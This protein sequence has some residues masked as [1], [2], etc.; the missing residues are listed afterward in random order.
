MA[1]SNGKNGEGSWEVPTNP[2]DFDDVLGDILDGDDGYDEDFLNKEL[3]GTINLNKKAQSVSAEI[4]QPAT[5]SHQSNPTAEATAALDLLTPSEV[6]QLLKHEVN[7]AGHLNKALDI[8]EMILTHDGKDNQLELMT[9]KSDEDL[10]DMYSLFSQKQK[11][12]QAFLVRMLELGVKTKI[13]SSLLGAEADAFV[14]QGATESVVT[15]QTTAKSKRLSNLI[16][17]ELDHRIL[18]HDD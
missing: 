18:P 2:D 15:P 6:G 10:R 1:K 9:L 5:T 8:I 16:R 17:N 14:S 13:L 12:S 7:R 4:L 3:E 11:N